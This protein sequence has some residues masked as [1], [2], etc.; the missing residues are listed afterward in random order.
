MRKAAM[1]Q[2][3][4]I[5]A[6]S[7]T[8]CSLLRE[9][10]LKSESPDKRRSLTLWLT[11]HAP[12]YSLR[13]EVRKGGE[14]IVAE[15]DRQDRL[16]GVAEIYWAPDSTLVAALVCDGGGPDYLRAFDTR[17]GVPLNANSFTTLL[18]ENIRKRYKPS[19]GELERFGGDPIKW[20]C[21]QET[22]LRGRFDRLLKNKV[23]P[24]PA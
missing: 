9:P 15:T 16:P 12:D 5:S 6:L 2:I 23:L 17:T 22:D 20:A 3:M 1:I 24:P 7:I 14:N 18:G 19:S 21:G 4:A 8:A 13:I 11:P 10:Y